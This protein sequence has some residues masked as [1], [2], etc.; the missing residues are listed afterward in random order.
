MRAFRFKI[1]NRPRIVGILLWNGNHADLRA[2]A[3]GG[4]GGGG[5]LA[6]LH[7]G[8][9]GGS[10]WLVFTFSLGSVPL[11][12]FYDKKKSQNGPFSF[13]FLLSSSSLNVFYLP[14]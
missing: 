1:G 12:F 7:D 5:D 9:D 8:L 13:V 14:L 2:A 6:G 10:W 3:N 11:Q 4:R